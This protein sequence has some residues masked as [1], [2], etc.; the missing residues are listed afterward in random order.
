[1]K[2]IRRCLSFFGLLA[3]CQLSSAA[4]STVSATGVD[5]GEFPSISF[6]ETGVSS[7]I[8][9]SGLN[10]NGL[11]IGLIAT[12]Y[13][14][15]AV[16]NLDPRLINTHNGDVLYLSLK[17]QNQNPISQGSENTDTSTK[18]LS[19]FDT[20]TGDLPFYATIDAGQQVSPGTYQ[21]INPIVIRWYYAIPTIAATCLLGNY[22]K[23]PGLV[24]NMFSCGV[25]NWGQGI[26]SQVSYRITILP[27]CRIIAN[28]I[29][30]GAAAFAAQFQP[31]QSSLGVRCS[32][33]TPYS[34]GLDDGQ[35]FANNQRHMQN[36][37]SQLSYEIFK[38]SDQQRWG[39]NAAERWSSDAASS[40]A[41]IYDGK[42]QQSYMMRA[43]I[44]PSNA[45][46]LPAGNYSDRIVVDISF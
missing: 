42:T 26:E 10:C 44:L 35:H 36:G 1:M 20:N 4:C 33:K 45:D 11:S 17:D 30:F 16:T 22:Y 39:K 34:V 15:Y 12:S 6:S 14:R 13:I 46:N 31:V 41:G 3:L 21:S 40:N 19:L 37:D 9:R 27:D 25:A 8:T 38:L 2:T 43:E 29:N 7:G 28:D 5:L 18:I 23:S 32:A 24:M